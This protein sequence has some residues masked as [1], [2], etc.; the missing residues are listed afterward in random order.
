MTMFT[1]DRA[2]KRDP[3]E[4][5]LIRDFV[6][7]INREIEIGWKLKSMIYKQSKRI[8]PSRV[9]IITFVVTIQRE[10]TA[11]QVAQTRVSCLNFERTAVNQ[12]CRSLI[13]GSSI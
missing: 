10:F 3:D 5:S 12:R 8:D 4:R 6:R 13:N 9:S 11:R 1:G 2:A 7:L